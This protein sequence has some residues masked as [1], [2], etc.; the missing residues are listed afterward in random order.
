MT[1]TS[2]LRV[3]Q[4]EDNPGDARLVADMLAP[5]DSGWA[6]TQ[7]PTLNEC[8]KQLGAG[9]F[10]VLLLDL[11][12]SDSHGIATLAAVRHDFSAIPIVV[13]SGF[14]EI[15]YG[16]QCLEKGAQDYL[17]KDEING[18]ILR[19]AM[20][21]AIER[22]KNEQALRTSDA[23]LRRFHESGLFGVIYW[24]LDGAL[25]YAN[26]RFLKMVGYELEELISGRVDWAQLTP[27]EYRSLDEA[28]FREL[29]ATGRNQKPY[30]KEYI[31]KD[32]S[33]IPVIVA[34]AILDEDS[35][36]GVSFILDMTESQPTEP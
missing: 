16:L 10:D 27:P 36:Q 21:Y 4:M 29:Q 1:S 14:E 19:R 8:L 33:R 34:S 2:T 28:S 6:L 22:A 9:S 23:R 15:H 17:V 20:R 26:N 5:A 12:V 3:L 24:D 30:K 13:L 32:G 11:D 18:R 7:I 35:V 31:R 25:V